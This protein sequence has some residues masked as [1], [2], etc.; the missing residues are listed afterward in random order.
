M[1]KAHLQQQ[2]D[3]IESA[4][5]AEILEDEPSSDSSAD[6][7]YD[8][9]EDIS[10]A[11]ESI[12][13]IRYLIDRGK[14]TVA[15]YQRDDISEDIIE[16]YLEDAFLAYFRL[17][18]ASFWLLIEKL[19]E[20]AEEFGFEDYWHEQGREHGSSNRPMPIYKLSKSL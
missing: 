4:A 18:R 20:A 8:L 7:Y 19:C 3:D 15:C 6:Y 16:H 9:L 13:T 12:N 14:G 5:I 11:S 2:L 1:E 10:R 17:H